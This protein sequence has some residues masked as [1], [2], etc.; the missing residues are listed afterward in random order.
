MDPEHRVLELVLHYEAIEVLHPVI[1]EIL[2]TPQFAI[3][4]KSLEHELKL[5]SSRSKLLADHEISIVQKAFMVLMDN[6]EHRV[7]AVELYVQE[8]IGLRLIVG[9]E[10]EEALQTA[11]N[12]RNL[13][14]KSMLQLYR[15]I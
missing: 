9:K 6:P 1:S 12:A 3:F 8:I 14:L 4:E 15:I 2:E 7:G 13:I 5:I 10:K 11:V